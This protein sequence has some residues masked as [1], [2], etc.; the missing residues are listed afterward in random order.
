MEILNMR[1]AG[2]GGRWSVGGGCEMKSH[3]LFIHLLKL[4]ICHMSEDVYGSY[5]KEIYMQIRYI[6]KNA[7]DKSVHLFVLSYV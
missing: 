4:A 1:I 6:H 7:F 2:N 3:L 5:H